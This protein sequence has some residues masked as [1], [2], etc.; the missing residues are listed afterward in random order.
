[1]GNAAL[2]AGRH[3]LSS[4]C[5]CLPDAEH[6]LDERRTSFGQPTPRTTIERGRNTPGEKAAT[7][8]AHSTLRLLPPEGTKAEDLCRISRQAIWRLARRNVFATNREVA[9]RTADSEWGGPRDR[10]LDSSVCRESSCLRRRCLYATHSRSARNSAREDGLR[11]N[12]AA[13]RTV[14]GVNRQCARTQA[15]HLSA[16]T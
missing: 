15:F 13:V 8:A 1:M 4:D 3:P 9:R 16:A 10:R 12:Q 11:A 6:R 14:A 7:G 2:V 5:R